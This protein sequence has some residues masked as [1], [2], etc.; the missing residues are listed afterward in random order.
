MGAAN[1]LLLSDD[2][3]TGITKAEI[4][5]ETLKLLA[6]PF[7][8]THGLRPGLVTNDLTAIIRSCV[9]VPW[10]AVHD[11]PRR[12]RH[13]E[14]ARALPERA[15]A[16]LSECHRPHWSKPG[17]GKLTRAWHCLVCKATIYDE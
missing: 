2:A 9:L 1:R 16:D 14:P 15:P 17:S 13:R 3:S 11:E 8:G 4:G 6:Y 7:R 5:E 10:G 12:R